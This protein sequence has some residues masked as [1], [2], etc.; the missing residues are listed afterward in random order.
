MELN[1]IIN[2]FEKKII[3]I[4][5]L[6]LLKKEYDGKIKEFNKFKYNVDTNGDIEYEII[7][8]MKEIFDNKDNKDNKKKTNITLEYFSNTYDET[9]KNRNNTEDLLNEY[10]KVI[11]I[12]FPECKFYFNTKIIIKKDSEKYE[13][14]YSVKITLRIIDT[15]KKRKRKR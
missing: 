10:H 2:E 13:D 14:I 11:N 4:R 3:L 6:H 1:N 5:N 8:Q 12:F 15:N 7:K 9:I